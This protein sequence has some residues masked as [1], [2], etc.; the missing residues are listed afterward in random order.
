MTFSFSFLIEEIS[1]WDRNT[2]FKV[3]Y[4]E[5][6]DPK[7]LVYMPSL[8]RIQG[9]PLEDDEIVDQETARVLESEQI[10]LTNER[11]NKS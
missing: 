11:T 4:T 9:V 5:D 8:A 6:Y 3:V 1:E 7:F 2:H 10:E